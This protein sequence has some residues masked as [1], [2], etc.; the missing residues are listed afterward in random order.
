MAILRDDDTSLDSFD[1]EDIHLWRWKES[2]SDL[3]GQEGEDEDDQ[4]SFDDSSLP[5]YE[6]KLHPNDVK[7]LLDSAPSQAVRAAWQ[8]GKALSRDEH[9][10]I[11]LVESAAAEGWWEEPSCT[12]VGELYAEGR[13][14]WNRCA[15][16][17][18]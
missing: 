3:E 5:L 10:R 13:E 8:S 1:R 14:W 15:G 11:L 7:S 18:A 9:C 16:L 4:T 6:L 12:S 17:S 2:R